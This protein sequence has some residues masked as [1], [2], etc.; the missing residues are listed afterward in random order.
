MVQVVAAVLERDGKVLVGQRKPEQAHPLKWEL[1]GGKVEPGE[2][3]AA[4]LVRELQEELAIQVR[5]WEEIARYDFTYP[6]KNPIE[7]FFYRV[8]QYAGEPQ[9]LIF[10]AMQWVAAHELLTVDF[11]EGDIPFLRSWRA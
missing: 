5:Q 2:S 11:L 4:A 1:P 8:S 7:L 9:N 10:H 3:P 6:G